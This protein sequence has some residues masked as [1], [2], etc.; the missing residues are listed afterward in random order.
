[1]LVEKILAHK[2]AENHQAPVNANRASSLGHPCVRYL[3][4]ERVNWQDKAM[5]PPRVRLIFD[6]GNDIE[7]RI[8]R[9]LEDAGFEL[10]EQQRSYSWPEYQITGHI[11]FKVLIEGKA[12][13]VECKSMA[14]YTFAK[15]NSVEDMLNAKYHYLRGYPA[16][17]TLYLLLDEKER[18][19]FILKDKSSGAMK[20]I[21]VDL[22]YDLG[23]SLLKKA[24]TVNA[25]VTAGTLPDRIEYDDNVC[26]E[27]GYAHICLP[28]VNRK[29][30]E[31]IDSA[32]LV[33]MLE[34]RAELAPTAKEYKE[35]D[36]EIKE[37]VKGKDKLM[38]G[39]WLITGKTVARKGY[40]VKEAEYWQ[41]SI[42][43]I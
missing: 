38:V 15:I 25:H 22:D 33:M 14:P 23:E 12:Y 10:I 39:D 1:M 37:Q 43:H 9:D 19:L 6:I 32:E 7:R 3:T 8:K 34:R 28:A 16:Q 35:L 27:C 18:G 31:I 42:K 30:L 17:I 4:Y 41:T 2:E 26:G 21:W 29:E 40:E 13:P 24:E 11:D 36:D 20:E 5:L